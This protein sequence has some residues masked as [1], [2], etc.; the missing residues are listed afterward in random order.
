MPSKRH[1][2]GATQNEG[3][4]AGRNPD[5][6]SRSQN[7]RT[8]DLDPR[9]TYQDPHARGCE[10]SPLRGTNRHE[11][12]QPFAYHPAQQGSELAPDTPLH[13]SSAGAQGFGS[14]TNLVHE[15]PIGPGP[16]GG[17]RNA[18]CSVSIREQFG[19]RGLNGKPNE[20]T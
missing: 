4:Q 8:N 10:A 1:S 13:A 19:T 15:F 7:S 3:K 6:S 11:D 17:R 2:G 14:A 20:V 9:T 5:H 18:I 12:A 16:V